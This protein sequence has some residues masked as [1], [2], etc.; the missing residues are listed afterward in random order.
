[1]LASDEHN[2]AIS[3]ELEGMSTVI[4]ATSGNAPIENG[5]QVRLPDDI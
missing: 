3:G 4:T 1:V 5:D 2:S